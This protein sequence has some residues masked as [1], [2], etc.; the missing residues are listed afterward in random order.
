MTLPSK[1]KAKPSRLDNRDPQQTH[2]QDWKEA[3]EASQQ[4]SNLV[5][6][7]VSLQY[8]FML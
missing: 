6:L 3:A 7:A 4:L 8:I 5:E 1:D 2:E